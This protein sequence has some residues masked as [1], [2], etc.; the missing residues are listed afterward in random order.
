MLQPLV[1]RSHHSP[2]LLSTV[3][4]VCRESR[5]APSC[6]YVAAAGTV[7]RGGLGGRARAFKLMDT[8]L[9][10]DDYEVVLFIVERSKIHWNHVV[11]VRSWL[12]S[13]C[14]SWPHLTGAVPVD[15]LL[16]GV[17][18]GD[19][20]DTTAREDVCPAPHFNIQ[21]LTHLCCSSRPRILASLLPTASASTRGACWQVT[22]CSTSHDWRSPLY[23]SPRHLCVRC[24]SQRSFG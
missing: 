19:D 1:L 11:L 18:S 23:A 2:C 6:L 16:A 4:L 8:A 5:A 17:S 10:H 3:L 22:A 7:C 13:L 20:T 9:A 24:Y 14:G 15:E 12:A 21:C